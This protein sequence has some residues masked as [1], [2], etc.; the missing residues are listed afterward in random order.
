M[1][2]W[3]RDKKFYIDIVLFGKI[4]IFGF[5]FVKLI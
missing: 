1:I 2:M 3:F 5:V 4:K